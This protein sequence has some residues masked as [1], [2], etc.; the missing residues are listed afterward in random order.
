MC[1]G[2]DPRFRMQ[3]DSGDGRLQLRIETPPDAP[4]IIGRLRC[5]RRMRGARIVSIVPGGAADRAG[6]SRDDL[7]IDI[8]DQ[9]L[10]TR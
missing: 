6:M 5:S 7:L 9:S 1:S 3:E 10:A 8:D 2:T 4:P